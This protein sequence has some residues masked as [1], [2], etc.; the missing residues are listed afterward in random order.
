MTVQSDPFVRHHGRTKIILGM[1]LPSFLNGR[2]LTRPPTPKSPAR[3][4]TVG[5]MF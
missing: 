3:A 1:L 5:R 4:Q 2:G